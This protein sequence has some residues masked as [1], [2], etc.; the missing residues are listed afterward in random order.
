MRCLATACA[1]MAV[2]AV[3]CAPEIEE[4]HFYCTDDSACPEGWYCHTDSRCYSYSGI[5][6]TSFTGSCSDC[7]PDWSFCVTLSTGGVP[8]KT[9]C[10][11]TCTTDRDCGRCG[12]C[13]VLTDGSVACMNRDALEIGWFCPD[14]WMCDI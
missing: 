3:S 12:K 6:E 5:C 10:S 8:Y 1:A 9:V 2:L 11:R 14:G 13:F 4:G 7:P